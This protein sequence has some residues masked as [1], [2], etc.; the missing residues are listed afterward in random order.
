[1]KNAKPSVGQDRPLR[2]GSH[3]NV[4]TLDGVELP[5]FVLVVLSLSSKHAVR[6]KFNE[7]H[8]V[9]DVDRFY[10][11]LRDMLKSCEGEYFAKWYAKNVHETPMDRK[12]KKVNNFL[13]DQKLQA[14]PF[15][16]GY[17]FCVTKQ[18]TIPDKQNESLVPGF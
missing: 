1:M 6:D 8:F 15:Y 9:A 10:C 13:R 12:I 16:K 3:Y 11:E 5:I 4:V 14:V 17:G 18:A 7:I 2:I